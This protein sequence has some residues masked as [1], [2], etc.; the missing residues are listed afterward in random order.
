MTQPLNTLRRK[1]LEIFEERFQQIKDG[2]EFMQTK[3]L[4]MFIKDME[5]VFYIGYRLDEVDPQITEL[6]E[7]AKNMEGVS[8]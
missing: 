2:P 7:E 6:Y 5:S 4:E 8:V 1:Q 3:R